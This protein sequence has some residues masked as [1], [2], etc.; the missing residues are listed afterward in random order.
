MLMGKLNILSKTSTS[1]EGKLY[2]WRI[3]IKIMKG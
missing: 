1:H 3:V 2:A